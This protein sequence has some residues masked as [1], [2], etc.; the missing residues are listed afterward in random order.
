MNIYE[1]EQLLRK[2]FEL[3]NLIYHQVRLATIQKVVIEVV[4]GDGIENNN[5][6][7]LEIS[8]SYDMQ[9]E[10]EELK[11][12]LSRICTEFSEWEFINS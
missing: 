11:K 10:D 8:T 4:L 2:K 9:D 5:G 6:I 12:F 1:F 7:E 3:Y